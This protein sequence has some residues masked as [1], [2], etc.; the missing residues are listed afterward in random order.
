[1]LLKLLKK[2]G[3]HTHIH[4]QRQEGA[5]IFRVVAEVPA[6][7]EHVFGAPL[8]SEI[9]NQVIDERESRILRQ[10][11]SPG[12]HGLKPS[13][14]RGR[15]ALGSYSVIAFE[16][17]RRHKDGTWLFDTHRIASCLGLSPLNTVGNAA[18]A[19][20]RYHLLRVG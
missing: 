10:H 5:R 15:V 2:L 7:M 4:T 8:V 1:M 17:K 16:K 9:L 13:N 20:Q 18:V 6:V 11:R 19:K 3:G 12:V 14:N